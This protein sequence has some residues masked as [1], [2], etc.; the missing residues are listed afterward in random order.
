MASGEALENQARRLTEVPSSRFSFTAVSAALAATVMPL[1]T[2]AW[3]L[4]GGDDDV[5]AHFQER[6]GLL[7]ELLAHLCVGSFVLEGAHVVVRVR[8]DGTAPSTRSVRQ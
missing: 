5:A 3:P 2:G 6:I 1:R 7:A 4:A 8:F